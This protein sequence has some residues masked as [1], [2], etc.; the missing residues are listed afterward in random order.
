MGSEVA[1]GR[2]EFQPRVRARRGALG[3]GARVSVVQ[4]ACDLDVHENVSREWAKELA[5]SLLHCWIPLPNQ[6]PL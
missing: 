1:D 2:T 3:S 5:A 4:A 6:H